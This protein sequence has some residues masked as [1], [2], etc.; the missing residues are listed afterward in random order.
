M[1][2]VLLSWDV[3]DWATDIRVFDS[4]RRAR[5]LDSPEHW[6]G[7]LDPRSRRIR[8]WRI[9]SLWRAPD[10]REVFRPPSDMPQTPRRAR[11]RERRQISHRRAKPRVHQYRNA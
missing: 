6:R 10:A 1:D 9:L 8:W 5:A 3:I 4:R 7:P 11:E 2:V